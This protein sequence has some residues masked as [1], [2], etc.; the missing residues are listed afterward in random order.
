MSNRRQEDA[1]REKKVVN[2]PKIGEVQLTILRV[3]LEEEP[4]GREIYV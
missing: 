3:K 1:L 2:T 4:Q